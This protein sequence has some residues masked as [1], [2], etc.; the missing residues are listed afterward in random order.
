M[1]AKKKTVS[2]YLADITAAL[3]KCNQAVAEKN[4]QDAGKALKTVKN[5][6]AFLKRNYGV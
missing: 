2:D 5:K 4:T 3:Q 1:A 6:L